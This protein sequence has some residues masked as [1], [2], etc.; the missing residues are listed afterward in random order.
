MKRPGSND[1][2]FSVVA[3]HLL[4]HT[5]VMTCGPQLVSVAVRALVRTAEQQVSQ[6]QSTVHLER[7]KKISKSLTYGFQSQGAPVFVATSV[8]FA[9]T[10]MSELFSISAYRSP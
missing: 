3:P 4:S 6:V 2:S 1:A 5:Y 7:K 10:C 8:W 9:Q